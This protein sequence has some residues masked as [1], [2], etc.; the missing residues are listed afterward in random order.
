M[1][2]KIYGD[3][4]F[5][6]QIAAQN[7]NGEPKTDLVTANVRVYHITGGSEVEDLA[8]TALSQVGST[9][10]YRYIWTNSLASGTYF[11]EYSLEDADGRTSVFV[12]DLPVL[13]VA[14]KADWEYIK[15]IE[16][17]RW[18][19]SNNQMVFY[20]E[21]GTTPLLTFNLYDAVGSPTTDSVYERRVAP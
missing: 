11:A 19:I 12:E 4:Q 15:K 8:S 6:L 18:K 20:D 7:L 10:I 3:T 14:T 9:N 21:D 17:G 16:T 5:E 1:L 13:S 2:V